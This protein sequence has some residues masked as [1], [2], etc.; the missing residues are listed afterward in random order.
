M[1]PNFNPFL[2][3]IAAL[4]LTTLACQALS[5]SGPASTQE[6]QQPQP[7]ESVPIETPSQPAVEPATVSSQSFM[8]P[9][10]YYQ[11][12]TVGPDVRKYILHVPSGYDGSKALPLVFV[13]HGRGGT[14]GG[15]VNT[16]GMNDKA[17]QEGFFVAYPEGMLNSDGKPVWNSG[18]APAIDSTADDV[19]FIRDL[20]NQL[21]GQLNV[22]SKR[23]Y[24]TGFSQGAALSYQLGATFPD[25]FAAVAP[26]AGAIGTS[27]D[28]GVTFTMI[29]E[30]KSPISVL[31]IHGKDDPNPYDGG[32]N[33]NNPDVWFTSV[34]DAVAFWTQVNACSGTPQTQTSADGNVIT[35]DYTACASGTEVEL[36]TILSGQHQWP[37]LSNHAHFVATDAVWEFFTR[38]SK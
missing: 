36:I 19:G 26:V 38:H 4:V 23:I 13:L 32:P 9:G 25:L 30:P 34:A 1:R 31:I 7:Q 21:E 18:T 11:T 29:P 20:L 27:S 3:T 5:D 12:I 37:T 22:D 17:D 16:T 6:P 8:A 15:M 10:D 24:A 35:D 33:G 14:A 2:Y 28:G